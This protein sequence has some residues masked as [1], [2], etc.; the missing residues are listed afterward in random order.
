MN[1]KELGQAV[2]KCSGLTLSQALRAIDCYHKAIGAALSGGRA[3][4]VNKFGAFDV[5]DP[6]RGHFIGGGTGRPKVRRISFIAA[7]EL[8]LS[9]QGAKKKRTEARPKRKK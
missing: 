4:R 2:A 8:R 7:Q 5:K 3:V 6:S 1:K 9:V